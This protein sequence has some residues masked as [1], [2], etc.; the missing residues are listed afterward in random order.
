MVNMSNYEQ[1]HASFTLAVPEFFNFGFD[2]VDKWAEDPAKL[3][4][5]WVDDAGSARAIPL[6]ICAASRIALLACCRAWACGRVM[7]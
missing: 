4:M 5:L 2:V 6:P 1:E 7:G 3:A